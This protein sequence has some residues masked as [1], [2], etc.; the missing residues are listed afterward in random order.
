[1]ATETQAT[2]TTTTESFEHIPNSPFWE[3][4]EDNLNSQAPVFENEPFS[5]ALEAVNEPNNNS[6]NRPNNETFGTL[7]NP[8]KKYKRAKKRTAQTDISE[9]NEDTEMLGI[10]GKISS[11]MEKVTT[12]PPPDKI[13]NF[14]KYV[15]SEVRDLPGNVQEEFIDETVIR[16]LQH[17]RKC[18]STL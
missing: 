9:D 8:P 3:I 17:K 1:M 5:G 6:S 7:P 13:T 11:S 18:R 12:T 14:V 2:N 10:L 15:E 16:L 4:E